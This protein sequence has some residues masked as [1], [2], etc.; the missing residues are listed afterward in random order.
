M[1]NNYIYGV[2][3]VTG[4]LSGATGIIIYDA[5]GRVKYINTGGGGVTSVSATS[6]ITS[7]G[8]S[9]PIISTLMNTNR[10]IGRSTA[11]AG[12]MEEIIIGSGLSLSAGT[13]SA[14]GTTASDSLSPLLLMGG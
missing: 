1:I 5:N 8:G 6:P 2:N 7:S 9:T 13:L 14:T 11:G 3:D 12:V 10:L 4:R